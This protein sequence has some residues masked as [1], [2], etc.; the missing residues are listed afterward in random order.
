LLLVFL[1]VGMRPEKKGGGLIDL[2][3]RRIAGD[4]AG[5]EVTARW[6]H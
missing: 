3:L 5:R 6:G 2:E 1:G 4:A